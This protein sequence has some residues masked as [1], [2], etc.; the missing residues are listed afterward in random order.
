MIGQ[1]VD[2]PLS[3]IMLSGGDI[4]LP[5]ETALHKRGIYYQVTYTHEARLIEVLCQ[6]LCGEVAVVN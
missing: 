5:R 2:T 4:S 3:Q 1:L 6:G